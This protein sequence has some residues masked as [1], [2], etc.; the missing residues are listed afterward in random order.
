MQDA[1][2]PCVGLVPVLWRGRFD[3]LDVEGVLSVLRN[4][5]SMAAP[6]FA[7]PEGMVV[8]HVAA[9][10]GFKKTIEKDGEPKSLHQHDL[11]HGEG[12]K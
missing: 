1:L 8:F 9:G 10:I 11:R 4:N 7:N 12:G 3:D 6:G 2:P 5:G